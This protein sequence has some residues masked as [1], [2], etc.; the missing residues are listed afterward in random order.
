MMLIILS[1][2]VAIVAVILGMSGKVST[3]KQRKVWIAAWTL[4]IIGAVLK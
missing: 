2:G 1:Y 4:A 3:E